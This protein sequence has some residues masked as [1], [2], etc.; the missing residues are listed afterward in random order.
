MLFAGIF[1]LHYCAIPEQGDQP[2]WWPE[3]SFSNMWRHDR[4][5]RFELFGRVA[6]RVDF[7]ACQGGMHQPKGHLANVLR[8]LQHDHR[9][10]MPQDVRG[11]PLVP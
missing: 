9:T 5:D 4:L 2:V 1:A 6:A 11:D 7:G 8:G 3:G 10:G